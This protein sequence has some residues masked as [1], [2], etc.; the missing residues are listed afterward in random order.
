VQALFDDDRNASQR[1]LDA[2]KAQA[3]SDAARARGAESSFAALRESTRLQW[4]SALA[5]ELEGEAG[6]ALVA[7]LSS[8]RELL[9]RALLRGDQPAPERAQLVLDL[10]GRS[11]PVTAQPLGA[12]GGVGAAVGG[13]SAGGRSLLFRA[14]LGTGRAPIAGQRLQGQLRDA[15]Q[16]AQAGVL[17]PASAIVWHAGQPWIYVRESNEPQPVDAGAPVGAAPAASAAGGKDSDDDDKPRG[18]EPRMAAAS[19]AGAAVPVTET[20]ADTMH[21]FQ[22]RA[23]PRARRIG[24][25]WFLQGYAEDDPVVVRGAQVLLSEELKY[26]IRNENDD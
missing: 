11:T 12:A 9:L 7:R 22:R 8:G 13:E 23:V 18:R 17:L 19:S 14:Q 10:P 20:R 25:R 3:A 24:D 15:G 16:A 6:G 4:G 1:A 26:Q 2:A 5:R 21:A